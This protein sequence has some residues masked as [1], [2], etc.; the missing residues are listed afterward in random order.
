[1]YRRAKH[2]ALVGLAIVVLGTALFCGAFYWR[3]TQGPVSLGLLSA[4]LEAWINASLDDVRVSVKDVVVERDPARGSIHVRMRDLDLSDRDGQM[5]ARAPRARIGVDAAALWSGTIAPRRLELIG[6]RILL[7][8]TAD[9]GV[10]LGFGSVT[11]PGSEPDEV[12]SDEVAGAPRM[13]E[14]PAG[15]QSS[16]V[17]YVLSRFSAIDED[18]GG[19]GALDALLISSASVS[20]FDEA[21][22]A[23]W[24]AP[25]A[26]L[27]VRR[28]PYGLSV[29]ADAQIDSGENS[30]HVEISA[31]YRRDADRFDVRT[32]V[33][34][35][36]P[37]EIS[38]EVFLLSELAE[39]R[40]PISGN[41]EFELDGTGT[42]LNAR[43]HFNI[44]AGYVGFPQVISDPLLVDEGVL[45][46]AYDAAAGAFVI[47]D[48]S[49]HIG[50]SEASLTGRLQRV[51]S[52]AATDY[53]RLD[54][55]ARNVSI[56]T[57]GTVTDPLAVDR[58]DLGGFVSFA[59]RR[60]LVEQLLISAGTSVVSV[61]GEFVQEQDLPSI[62]LNGELKEIPLAVLKKI[63]PPAAAPGAR[64][65]IE[66]HTIEGRVVD[67]TVE[68]NL[69]A[70]VLAAALRSNP[71]P[72]EMIKVSFA[73]AD[74]KTRYFYDLPPIHSASGRGV[75]SGNEFELWLDAGQ[76]TLP[77]GD[78]LTLTSGRFF[79]PDLMREPTPG[80]IEVTVDGPAGAM[81]ALIDEEPLR[82]AAR[83]DIEPDSL[84]GDA[85][86]GISLRLPLHRDVTWDEIDI[87]AKASIEG[88]T[89]RTPFDG[90]AID[91]GNVTIDV[92]E[93]GLEARGKVTFNGV[94]VDLLKIQSFDSA[95]SDGDRLLLSGRLDEA[96]RT[97]LG[98]DLANILR[99]P[100]DAEVSATD[101]AGDISNLHVRADLS[102][103]ELR[104]EPIGWRY[105]PQAKTAISFDLTTYPDGGLKLD[106]IVLSGADLAIEGT[107]ALDHNHETEMVELPIVV[108]GTAN[109]FSVSGKRVDQRNLAITVQG[110]S[111]DA[112]PMVGAI[113]RG[114]DADDVARFDQVG[115]RTIEVQGR[116]DTLF[117][118][119]QEH[120]LDAAASLRMNGS[121]LAHLRLAGTFFDGKGLD[122]GLEP[123]NDGSRSL[124]LTS[125]N[126]GAVLRA[127]NLYSRI[128]GGRLKL[129]AI[130]GKPG[131]PVHMDGVLRI[132]D[133]G[134]ENEPALNEA[135]RA[136]VRETRQVEIS[137]FD[138]LKLPFRVGAERIEIGETLLRGANVGAS[139]RGA[140]RKVDGGLDL[141]GTF[142]P[143][144]GLNSAFSNVPL[145]GEV[146]MGGEG[147][148]LF[149]VTFGMSGTI[150]EP[151]IVINPVSA[152]APG[153]LRRLFEFGGPVSSFDTEG[154]QPFQPME[155]IR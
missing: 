57:Q 33:S 41:A 8:R 12:S 115:M 155:S 15:A 23:F 103:A 147:Q 79:V 136:A 138:E 22:S 118:H 14:A 106:H 60:L 72:N 114:S 42:I 91:G 86:T 101:I 154:S 112:R 36:I 125:T 76:V 150:E 5:I 68:I 55:F 38:D 85:T 151:R 18:A 130:L 58:V 24:Y 45:K 75:I 132:V 87:A 74:V 16:F 29:I 83:A 17:D 62:R 66:K 127:A 140:I 43:A 6:A 56:D 90:I 67:G 31:D 111:F 108:L 88:V 126:A 104:F 92:T 26:N 39:V 94:P 63:W 1:M 148:G 13:T 121:R 78:T 124:M 116:F 82:Y 123:R 100:V 109:E 131:S 44:D 51:H 35:L 102:E 47:E 30:W 10:Q 122:L 27:I 69:P 95:S 129:Q 146:L 93:D 48:S 134:V 139:A 110:K 2:V 40:V 143:V 32:Q 11:T 84:G 96:A 3:L 99:G 7:K 37:A 65:W 28:M 71:I 81:L 25:D 61:K 149:G 145:L 50:G 20:M 153:F 144:Y 97:R 21:N 70:G 137:R 4:P 34:D 64:D 133:F 53:M 80:E 117:A 152:L 113:F 107:L 49:I 128:R 9:G 52:D 19:R 119:G 77:S 120:L 59:E 141:A 73:V 89:F 135:S 142:I 105:G 98:I 54:L 46:V